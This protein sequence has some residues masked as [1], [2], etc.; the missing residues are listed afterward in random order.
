M[1]HATAEYLLKARVTMFKK[2]A[3]LFIARCSCSAMSANKLKCP[4]QN[5]IILVT[6]Q[7]ML[8]PPMNLSVY[9]AVL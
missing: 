8:K 2:L 7:A 6:P 9:T 1:F 4:T 5:D 3:F